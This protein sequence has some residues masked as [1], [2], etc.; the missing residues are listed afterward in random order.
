MKFL[1]FAYRSASPD[2]QHAWSQIAVSVA[3]PIAAV[4]DDVLAEAAK[5][6]N[7]GVTKIDADKGAAM[8]VVGE[9]SQKL[10]GLQ[11]KLNAMGNDPR[12]KEANDTMMGWFGGMAAGRKV[13]R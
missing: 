4:I 11:G 2:N 3:D 1:R 5:I 9:S 12:I 7:D 13:E 8:A 6:V 10:F